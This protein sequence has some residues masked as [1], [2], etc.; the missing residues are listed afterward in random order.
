MFYSSLQLW[1]R[2][3]GK[4]GRGLHHKHDVLN[5]DMNTAQF[6]NE[7]NSTNVVLIIIL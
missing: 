1:L 7:V 2:H 3:Y 4:Y 5:N 6:C